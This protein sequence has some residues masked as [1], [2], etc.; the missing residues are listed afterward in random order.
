VRV[1]HAESEAGLVL[2]EAQRL[3]PQDLETD[4][5]GVGDAEGRR[6]G[7]A[8]DAGLCVL[9]VLDVDTGRGGE[10]E[11]EIEV[12]AVERD[13][14]IVE[15]EHRVCPADLRLAGRGIAHVEC[16]APNGIEAERPV[17]IRGGGDRD[18]D[19]EGEARHQHAD[20]VE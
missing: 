16:A 18:V 4:V 17:F 1:G 7:S 20:A 8:D 2:A 13:R 6:A 12:A 14:Q 5:E 15:F 19:P 11:V 10:R 9:E 3:R